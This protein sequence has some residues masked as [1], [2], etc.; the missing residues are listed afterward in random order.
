M[1]AVFVNR[2]ECITCGDTNLHSLSKGRFTEEPLYSYLTNDPWGVSPLPFIDE[3]HWKLV[4]CESCSQKFHAR[5]LD[6][7]WLQTYYS[8]WISSDSITAYS[9]KIA[10]NSK[11]AKAKHSVERAL[12]IEKATR[13]L[14]G[15]KAVRILD[16]GCGDG[17]FLSM[18]QLFGFKCAAIEFSSSRHQRRGI[19]VY[20]S[21]QEMINDK[22]TDAN[23]DAITMFEVLE[24]LPNPRQT[25]AK[26]TKYLKTGG[27]FILETP[28][29]ENVNNILSME[30]YRLIHPLGHINAFTPDTMK[31]IAAQVDL[32]PLKPG[33]PQVSADYLRVLKREMRRLLERFRN[34][35][36]QMFFVKNIETRPDS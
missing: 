20:P 29:C 8:E 7:K 3:E 15:K 22:G 19:D 14:R 1:K 23:F 6:E 2:E 12:L 26:L 28:N 32:V 5:I 4:Q 18:C 27:I 11:F 34:P 31:K 36:T 17:D 10:K 21:S 13:S 33:T 24:H 30:D 16:F 9:E 35:S 25:L